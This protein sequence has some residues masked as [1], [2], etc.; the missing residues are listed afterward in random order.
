LSQTDELGRINRVDH[1]GISDL[2]VR[3]MW[4][5]QNPFKHFDYLTKDITDYTFKLVALIPT[6]KFNNFSNVE[7]FE[8]FCKNYG[9]YISD[10]DIE[11]PQ[12]PANF[13]NSKLIIYT[14]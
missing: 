1:L 5:I 3:S 14:I 10:E 6:A 11:D 13:I 7:E 8:N 2:R 9:V 12:N 4:L